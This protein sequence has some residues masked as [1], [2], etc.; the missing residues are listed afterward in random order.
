MLRI[1]NPPEE[2]AR[3]A[4][5]IERH[6]EVAEGVGGMRAPVV[7]RVRAQHRVLLVVLGAKR[8]ADADLEPIIGR[9]TLNAEPLA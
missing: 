1:V 4:P 7:H 8:S 5:L 9:E 2:S 6:G 3:T